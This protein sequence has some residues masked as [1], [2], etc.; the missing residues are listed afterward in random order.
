G[1]ATRG[2][3]CGG[4]K[5]RVSAYAAQLSRGDIRREGERTRCRRR[6]GLAAPG[7]AT[8]GKTSMSHG[9]AAARTARRAGARAVV[10]CTAAL[11]LGTPLASTANETASSYEPLPSRTT[12]IRGAV[13]LDG[14]GGR[15]AESDLLLRDGRIAALG[16]ELATPEGAVVID[17]AG[18]WVTP[19]IID[20]HSHLG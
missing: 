7:A 12:L 5:R 11:V 17:A 18:R 9:R 20:V 19:G 8:G 3:R 16:T 6:C 2:R 1:R 14:A 10:A 13:V 15:M 4:D